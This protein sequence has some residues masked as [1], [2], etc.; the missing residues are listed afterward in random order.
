MYGSSSRSL[1][2]ESY[3]SPR[4]LSGFLPFGLIL[5][6]DP[7]GVAGVFRVGVLRDNFTGWSCLILSVTF[8][9]FVFSFSFFVGCA[10]WIVDPSASLPSSSLGRFRLS[11]SFA[12]GF[13]GRPALVFFCLAGS[14]T[15]AGVGGTDGAFVMSLILRGFLAGAG[16]SDGGVLCDGWLCVLC[17]GPLKLWDED[18]ALGV[19]SFFTGLKDNFSFVTGVPF[20]LTVLKPRR[21]DGMTVRVALFV[22][23]V[24]VVLIKRAKTRMRGGRRHFALAG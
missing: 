1:A 6:P 22:G 5:R 24:L 11:R 19:S 3:P 7:A 8:W 15:A 9:V 23:E 16:A 10:T 2:S 21:C 13:G 18:S 14:T 17:D 4:G 12:V 20:I